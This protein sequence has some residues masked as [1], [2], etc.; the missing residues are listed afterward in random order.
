MKKLTR[1]V[2]LLLLAVA[3]LYSVDGFSQSK[4]KKQLKQR[5][6]VQRSRLRSRDSLMRSLTRSDTSINSRLQ[7][8]E[9]YVNTF[10]QID[11]SLGEGIDTVEIG[12]QIPRVIRSIDRISKAAQTHKSATLRYLFVLRDNLDRLQ[13]ELDGWQSDMQDVDSKLIQNQ[14]DI[15]K[16][17]RDTTLRTTSTD[18]AMRHSFIVQVH[19]LRVLWRHTDSLN[20]NILLQ[21]NF[22][23]DKIGMSYTK[24]LDESDEIDNK[25]KGFAMKAING[26]SDYLWKTKPTYNDFREALNRTITLD[27]LLLTYF[28]RNDIT[29]HAVAIAMIVLIFTWLLYNRNKVLSKADNHEAVSQQAGYLYYHPVLSA[30]LVA[31]IIVPLLYDHPPTVLIE[32]FFLISLILS[33]ILIR[34]ELSDK[35]YRFLLK[36]LFITIIYAISNLFIEIANIDRYIV[37]ALSALSIAIASQ[38][39]AE[40]KKS[41]EGHL[42]RTKLA[43]RIFIALQI[44]SVILNITGRFSLSKIAGVTAVFNLW[45]ILSLYVA[46]KVILEG[47]F[48]NFEAKKGSKSII[49][50][51]DYELVKKKF[52]N[53]LILAGTI[54]WLFILLQNL[55]IDDWARDNIGDFLNQSQSIANTSFTFG[56]FVIFILVI[57]LSSIVSK[58]I[59]YF[60]DVSAR[61]VTDLSVLRRK[62]RTSALIIRIGVFTVGFLLAVAASG[63]PL[64]KLTIIIS[65]F[66][67]GIG[68]GLQNIVNNLVSGLILAFEKP[69][70]IGDVIEVDGHTGTMKEIGIRSSKVITGDGSEVIIPNGDF[71]S[72]QVVNWTLSNSNRQI[73]LRV[74]TAYGV[75]VHKVRELFKGLLLNR[76]DI[77]STPAPA[78]FV[79]NVS[80]SAVEFK[81]LFWEADISSTGELR[82]KILT[83][84]YELIS[85]ENIPLPGTQKD[86]NLHFPEGIPMGNATT[87]KPKGNKTEPK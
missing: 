49:N 66:G 14:N 65:A 52:R 18:T 27:G 5:R 80:E 53:T 76:E 78:V 74:I 26:E 37:L 8:I 34:K 69:I 59:S 39:L 29:Q 61:R 35:T 82:S 57:W 47:L 84:V 40:V 43:L 28:F 83:E 44:V 22:L 32:L 70:N 4:E 7:R 72:H 46:I 6:E 30:L 64:D 55:N 42:P 36:L 12:E 19:H 48:L 71:I 81:L 86:I 33:T 9:Q 75:D 51:M 31:A 77:M 38:Y 24:V 13:T 2:S 79:N 50:W 20:R 58:I 15:L 56:G 87:E 17:S 73:D 10:N 54:L 41:P 68:F 21:V 11:N 16:F 25:I 62:N 45:L 1:N 67:V 63:F 3:L 60:Y 85:R 23:Q